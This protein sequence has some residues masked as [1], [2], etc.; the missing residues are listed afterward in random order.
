[1]SEIEQASTVRPLVA[2][3][4]HCR[5]LS[6]SLVLPSVAVCYSVARVVWL[7]VVATS[8]THVFCP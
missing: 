8:I 4:G 3:L 2:I 6:S 1:M 5:G 7:R